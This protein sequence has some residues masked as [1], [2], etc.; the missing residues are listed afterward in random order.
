MA[1]GAAVLFIAGSNP[2]FSPLLTRIVLPL[3]LIVVVVVV[4]VAVAGQPSCLCNHR[5]RIEGSNTPIALN[6]PS[7][8]I[9]DRRKESMGKWGSVPAGAFN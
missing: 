7:I 3:G 2:L 5:V 8:A 1:L 9:Y 4:V 6:L